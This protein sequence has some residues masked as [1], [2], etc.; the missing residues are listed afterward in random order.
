MREARG[1][2][3]G[4]SLETSTVAGMIVGLLAVVVGMAMKGAPPEVLL[5]P[6]A[7]L[8]IFVGDRKHDIVGAQVNAIDSLAVGYGYGSLS[9]LQ[10]ANPTYFVRTV[11]ELIACLA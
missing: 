7:V 4:I 9:E 10:A 3:G 5:N 6:A 11:A 8:I 2:I 1:G